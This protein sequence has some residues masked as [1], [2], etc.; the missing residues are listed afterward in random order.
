MV[1]QTLW[2]RSVRFACF[3]LTP[4]PTGV[5]GCEF[6]LPRPKGGSVE[7]YPARDQPLLIGGPFEL[8]AEVGMGEGNHRRGPL[9]HG[10]ALQIDHSVFGDDVHDVRARRR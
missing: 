1:A 4:S 3:P 7:R 2:S 5:R 8:L 10:F 9:G 6:G